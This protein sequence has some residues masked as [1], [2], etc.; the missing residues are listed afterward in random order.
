MSGITCC[1]GKGWR[2]IDHGG[3]ISRGAGVC[4]DLT[5]A[6]DSISAKDATGANRTGWL[7]KKVA[8]D[9]SM[10]H[11]EQAYTVVR[12]CLGFE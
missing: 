5:V 9:G 10:T 8:L 11:P 2:R 12:R 6:R 3:S 4:L 7:E 1:R